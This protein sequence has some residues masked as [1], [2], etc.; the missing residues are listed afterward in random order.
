MLDF[1]N[2]SLQEQ[3]QWAAEGDA[4][5]IVGETFFE[6]GEA[7]MALDAIQKHGQGETLY[8]P[9]ISDDGNIYTW[10]MELWPEEMCDDTRGR[11]RPTS[12]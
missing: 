1:L 10:Y 8:R 2:S 9:M 5:F 3:A 11:S 6:Y 12:S 7:K 4:D